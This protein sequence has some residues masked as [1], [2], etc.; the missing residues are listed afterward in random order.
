MTTNDIRYQKVSVTAAGG[1]ASAGSKHF[2]MSIP[3][4][5]AKSIGL[6]PD[7]RSICIKFDGSRVI[8]EKAQEEGFT[9]ER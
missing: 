4:N 6:T 9:H 1:N 7:D 3:S 8:L 5:W 2:R